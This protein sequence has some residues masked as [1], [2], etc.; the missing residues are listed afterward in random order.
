[1]AEHAKAKSTGAFYSS[2]W[3]PCNK[4]LTQTHLFLRG[5]PAILVAVILLALSLAAD[6]GGVE[7]PSLVD[8]G[9]VALVAVHRVV[10]ARRQQQRRVL[11][12]APVQLLPADRQGADSIGKLET[13]QMALEI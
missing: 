11:P 12:T 5:E 6:D 7:R 13:L 4:D 10:V 8:A 3:S 1:M 9:E 2:A